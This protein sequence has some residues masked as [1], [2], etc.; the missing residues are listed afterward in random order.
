MFGWT[1][2]LRLHP[3]KKP[4]EGLRPP[5][6]VVS[7]D[8]DERPSL[9]IA[10]QSVGQMEPQLYRPP[11]HTSGIVVLSPGRIEQGSGYELAVFGTNLPAAQGLAERISLALAPG[12]AAH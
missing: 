2:E 11:E 5:L 8:D 6:E 3:G 1:I 10:G 7:S 9:P 4:R 12:E